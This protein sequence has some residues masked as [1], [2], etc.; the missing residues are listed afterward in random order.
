MPALEGSGVVIAQTPEAG[1]IVPRGAT[2]SVVLAA[3][4]LSEG[5]DEPAEEPETQEGVE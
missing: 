1:A 2:I 5:R 3:P 4:A